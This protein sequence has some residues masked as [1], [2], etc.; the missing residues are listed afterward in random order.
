[1]CAYFRHICIFWGMDLVILEKK[2][3]SWFDCLIHRQYALDYY[4]YLKLLDFR[5]LL[6]FENM[7]YS[8]CCIS[9]L[10]VSVLIKG[11]LP[12]HTLYCLIITC[13]CLLFNTLWSVFGIPCYAYLT[14]SKVCLNFTKKNNFCCM[15]S[16]W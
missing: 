6:R 4:F 12:L 8:L 7:C 16:K 10:L 2:F 3:F 15:L 14:T 13:R 1:M 9:W 11:V 5:L